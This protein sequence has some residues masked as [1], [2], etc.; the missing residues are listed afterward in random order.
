MVVFNNEYAF[1]HELINRQDKD[2]IF[3]IKIGSHA[4]E[5]AGVYAK[6]DKNLSF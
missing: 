1:I 6:Y 3:Q 4:L 2:N 5:P